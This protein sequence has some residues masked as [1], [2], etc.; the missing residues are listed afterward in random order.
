MVIAFMAVGDVLSQLVFVA[1]IAAFMN[2]CWQRVAASQFAIYMSLSNLS[3][4]IGAGLFALIA[5]D[6]SYTQAF[7]MMSVSFL[8]AAAL[9][10]MFD[11][12][13]AHRR[14]AALDV[15]DS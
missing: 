10:A 2:I 4:S 5:A 1:M 8:C 12:Q 3:R 15:V 14:L 6:V 7:Y 11:E 13:K 9:L